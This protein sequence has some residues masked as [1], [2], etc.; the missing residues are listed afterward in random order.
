MPEPDL[1]EIHDFLV[2]LA[3]KAGPK[4]VAANPS[5]VDT[6]KNSSDLVT[7]TDKA[8]E[9]LISSS[10]KSNYPDY[11]F[12]GEETAQSG[13]LTDAPTFVVDPIDG[14][15]NFVH[16]H[17]YISISLAFA[18][19]QEALIGVVYNPFTQHLYTAIKG[20][21]AFLT[22]PKIP[23]S[24][25]AADRRV[26]SIYERRK[27]PLRSSPP[28]LPDLSGALIAVEYGNER[29]G[30]NW[31][32]KIGTFSAL[33]KDKSIDGAMV[34]SVRSLGSAALNMCSVARG[35][36]DIYWEGG[37]WAWDVAAGWV[38]VEESGGM[39]VGG[40]KGEWSPKVDGRRYLVL[41]AGAGK[42]M[43]DEF[44]SKIKAPTSQ[45]HD[46]T[47]PSEVKLH[48][49][50]TSPTPNALSPRLEQP[51]DLA[52][53]L[54]QYSDLMPPLSQ[55][56]SSSYRFILLRNTAFYPFD[57]YESPANDA[58]EDL[59]PFYGNIASRAAENHQHSIPNESALA[60]G[61]GRVFANFYGVQQ[62][63]LSWQDLEAFALKLQQFVKRGF[64]G[65]LE[66]V[67][68]PPHGRSPIVVNL[69]TFG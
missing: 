53:L 28:P 38:I 13:R 3:G 62:R 58:S 46:V 21:G 7:E 20:Q 64:V 6:K 25:P 19:K 31:D 30:N 32:C 43:V 15:T 40:N 63:M 55:N 56:P 14:T 36:L 5:T 35:D 50:H 26:E 54:A 16:A 23:S 68:W 11:S 51:T 65:K 27:L 60:F 29:H 33:G 52:S 42:E 17:P 45:A 22:A 49:S 37:C 67:M 69:A 66:M 4:I 24:F 9:D 34:Q 59:D 47:V 2:G 41:R 48:P 12:L 8:V 39:V 10:L 18:Y 57:G 61:S 1:Q 44:W